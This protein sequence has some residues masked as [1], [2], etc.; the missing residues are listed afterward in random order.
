MPRYIC[1]SCGR[2]VELPEPKRPCEEP[3]CGSC[4]LTLLTIDEELTELMKGKRILLVAYKPEDFTMDW[5]IEKYTEENE[6]SLKIS[7]GEIF[8]LLEDGT[9][10]RTWNTEWGGVDYMKKYR[11]VWDADV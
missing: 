7:H 8:I 4:G 3:R 1:P 6:V 5:E 2:I 11:E 9:T 10:I